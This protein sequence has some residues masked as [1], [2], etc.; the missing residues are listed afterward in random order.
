M[1]QY[2]KYILVGT[3]S[4][5]DGQLFYVTH[6]RSILGSSD[7]KLDPTHPSDPIFQLNYNGGIQFNLHVPHS[8]DMRPLAFTI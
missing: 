3:D 8:N 4:E 6:I 5:S 2:I 7:Y 1:S